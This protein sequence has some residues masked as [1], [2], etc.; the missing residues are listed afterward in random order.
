MALNNFIS[1]L[2]DIINFFLFFLTRVEPKPIKNAKI[3]KKQIICR[4]DSSVA[5]I[6]IINRNG[7]Q[8]NLRRQLI[9][10]VFTRIVFKLF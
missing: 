10:I 9:Y 8:I 6:I 2:M 4:I 1:A 5:M 7:Y 3:Q